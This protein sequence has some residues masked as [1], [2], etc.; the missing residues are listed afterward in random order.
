MVTKFHSL[1]ILLGL[2]LV[3]GCA[4]G[5]WSYVAR[6]KKTM[7]MTVFVHGSVFTGLVLFNAQDAKKDN[8]TYDCR[9]VSML[10]YIRQQPILQEDQILLNQGWTALSDELFQ[11]FRKDEWELAERRKATNFIIPIYEKHAIY[12]KDGSDRA[13]FTFGHLGLLSQLYRHA[14]SQELYHHIAD[15]VQEYKKTYDEVEVI[16]VAHS[17]GSNIVINISDQE[18]IYHRNVIINCVVMF[19]APLQVENAERVLHPMFKRV[20]HCYAES[21][22][23]QPYDFFSTRHGQ[24]YKL[25]SDSGLGFTMP[26]QH[27]V[28]TVRLQVN[29]RDR[30]DHSNMWF[31]GRSRRASRTLWPLPLMVL[32]PHLIKLIDEIDGGRHLDCNIIDTQDQFRLEISPVDTD[33]ILTK[34]ENIR[35]LVIAHKYQV[36]KQWKP[37]D[38]ATNMLFNKRTCSLIAQSWGEPYR[39]QQVTA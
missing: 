26:E 24:S 30:P 21:D 27:N 18:D 31:I 13:Y 20:V 22:Q 7:T 2:V 33:M 11:Q 16:L 4:F 9:Y 34:T 17:H 19:G 5:A 39:E 14:A 3:I 6:P 38:K 35:P 10:K 37:Q 1:G 32:T 25:F 28:F 15:T 29:H 12:N 23:V 36:K 8:L